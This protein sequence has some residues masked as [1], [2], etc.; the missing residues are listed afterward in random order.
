MNLRHN[1]SFLAL[2]KDLESPIVLDKT[3]KES[4]VRARI[5][6]SILQK[7]LLAVEKKYKLCGLSDERFLVASHI[8]LWSQSN[9]I[10]RLDVND[11]QK[12]T[13][14]GTD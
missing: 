7:A 13:W 14:N 10:E 4:V 1:E 11:G 8:K 9:H 2:Q 3:E 12:N 5:G 6:Q